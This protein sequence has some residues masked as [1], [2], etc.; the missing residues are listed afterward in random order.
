MAFTNSLPRN[1]FFHS[2]LHILLTESRNRY[3]E[4]DADWQRRSFIRG[5]LQPVQLT[6]GFVGIG[7]LASALVSHL[8]RV[9]IHVLIWNRTASKCADLVRLGAILA[10][11]P[12]DV[13]A[14]SDIVFCSVRGTG[15][16][17][18]VCFG[19]YF[20]GLNGIV[21]GLKR[22]TRSEKGFVM[23]SSI[24]PE[25]SMIIA[26]DFRKASTKYL[27]AQALLKSQSEDC[28]IRVLCAGSKS[29]FEKLPNCF[30]CTK[31]QFIY[32]S[33]LLGEAS[34]MKYAHTITHVGYAL[35]LIEALAVLQESEKPV[36]SLSFILDELDNVSPIMRNK[37]KDIIFHRRDLG[38][39]IRELKD[40]L[41]E[42]YEW[43]PKKPLH[44]ATAAFEALEYASRKGADNKNISAMY[45][46]LV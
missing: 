8:V 17:T 4:Y 38:G 20:V 12:A 5:P 10:N 37:I 46:L 3:V 28:D 9:G 29:L 32:I 24:R 40:T 45:D 1:C 26:Q 34:R 2:S 15:P 31:A 44:L 18:E 21:A 11:T 39:T 42:L 36:E 19:G 23:L 16:I 33:T 7:E 41:K 35:S 13:A 25:T 14:E 43:Y 27:E 30:A 22:N 6:L